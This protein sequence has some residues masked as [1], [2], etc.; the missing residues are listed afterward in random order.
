MSLG[1]VNFEILDL[2]GNQLT[3]DAK[4]LFGADKSNLVHLVLSRNRLSFDFTK[5][6]MPVGVLNSSLLVLELSHNKIYGRLP[7]WLGL[8]SQMYSFDVSYN[9]LCGPIPTIGGKLQEF[10]AAAFQ[11]NKCL[12]G[13]P[14]P[15]CNS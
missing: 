13:A 14:L 12:C 5:V 8:S 2:S 9:R 6:V 1:K 15:P 10:Q 11:H 7:T 3:G 4:F